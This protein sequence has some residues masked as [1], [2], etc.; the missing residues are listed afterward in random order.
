M[1]ALL[2]ETEIISQVD[3]WYLG[4]SC[5][6]DSWY[7]GKSC[8]DDSHYPGKPSRQSQSSGWL[9]K[10]VTVFLSVTPRS[11]GLCCFDNRFKEMIDNFL[12]RGVPW[13][14]PII[15]LSLYV[16]ELQLLFLLG[17]CLCLYIVQWRTCFYLDFFQMLFRSFLEMFRKVFYLEFF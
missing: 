9:T 10:S 6:V 2:N 12:Q 3:S 1:T 16:Y 11:T 17:M 13:S 14:F 8:Q 7:L 5:Q 4:K 15:C